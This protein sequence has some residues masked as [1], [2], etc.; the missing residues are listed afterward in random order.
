[1]SREYTQ[2]DL[3]PLSGIQHFCFC[4]RQWALIHIERQWQENVLTIEGKLMHEKAD[5]P[6]N[7]ETRQGV[8]ITRAMPVASYQLGLSGVCDIVEFRPDPN[9]TTLNGR[10]GR[11]LPSPVEYKRGQEK[12]DECDEVQLCAQALCLEEML[13]VD[14]PVGYLYYGK[15]RRRTVVELTKALRNL[16]SDLSAEMHDYFRKGYT[17]RVKPS[18]KCSACSLA[19]LCLPK[20]QSKVIPASKYI[21]DHIKEA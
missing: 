19:D 12:D 3:L 17:P 21:Q 14:I 16:A 10:E 11:F 13:C 9:G 5:D 20:L 6:F 2:E 1:M 4:R 18:K 7:S 15:T 8:I